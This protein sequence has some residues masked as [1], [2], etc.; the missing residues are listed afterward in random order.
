MRKK[1]NYRKIKISVKLY[2]KKMK[3]IK[4]K[5]ISIRIKNE[6]KQDYLATYLCVRKSFIKRIIYHKFLYSYKNYIKR[7]K[8]P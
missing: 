5:Y 7:F 1:S 4:N 2:N 8:I 6:L 3:E